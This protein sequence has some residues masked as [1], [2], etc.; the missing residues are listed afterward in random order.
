MNQH[1]PSLRAAITG[2]EYHLPETVVTNE[3]LAAECPDWQIDK[4]AEKTG[5][6]ERHLAAPCECSS[7][8][9]AAAARKLF[10]SGCVAPEQIDAILL[11]TQS[12]DYFLPTTACILQDRLGIPT[13]AAALDFNLGCSGF[14][15]GL[16][17]AKG[18]VETGQARKVLLLTA[19]TYSKFIHPGDRSVRVLFGDGAA[20]TLVEALPAGPGEQ[21]IAPPVWGSD[22]RG[23]RNLIVPTGGARTPIGLGTADGAGPAPQLFMNGPEIFNFTAQRIPEVVEEVLRRNGKSIAE[24]DQFV[25]HQ[26]SKMVLDHLR[27]KLR[28]PPERFYTAIEDCGNT[29][30][31]TIPIA[32]KRACSDGRIAP[33]NSVLLAGFGVG[34]SWAATLIRW[35]DLH[36]NGRTGPAQATAAG[37]QE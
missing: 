19:E 20:A 4:I 11:C 1:N 16:G 5:I 33:G 6:H 37:P 8:L 14:V 3:D 15:Y 13:T 32:L 28:I 26:A 17:L 12:P 10:D 18:L 30:S 29:V 24:I 9:A 21:F 36:R 22:G 25:F 31:S 34:Y 35:A 27:R 23:A 7:D 2:I